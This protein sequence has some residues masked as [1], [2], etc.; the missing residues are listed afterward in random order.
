MASLVGELDP[1]WK[2]EFDVM[3]KAYEE[4]MLAGIVAFEIPVTRLETR[5]KLSQNRGRDEQER[6]AARLEESTDS[7]ERA[8]AA[9][10]STFSTVSSWPLSMAVGDV[11]RVT[12]SGVGTYKAVT[13][14]M[15][16]V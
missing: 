9:D 14:P 5:W 6:I 1:Q 7:A 8:L 15:E 4:Q 3:P 10:Q 2:P 11:L 16:E 13:V 12:I